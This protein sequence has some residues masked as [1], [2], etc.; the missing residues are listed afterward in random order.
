MSSIDF[1]SPEPPAPSPQRSD[2]RRFISGAWITGLGTLAS[3]VLGLLRDIAT[4]ALLGLAAYGVAD[5]LVVAIR[6]P[7]LFRRIFGEGALTASFI[8]AFA[9]EYEQSADDGWKLAT[10]VLVWLTL[11][12]TAIVLIAEII[13]GVAWLWAR[14]SPSAALLISFIAAN[15]PYAITICVASLLGATLQAVGRFTVAAWAPTLLNICWLIAAWFVAPGVSDDRVVQAWVIIGSIQLAGLL[16]AIVHLPAL[17][18]AGFHF[19]YDWQSSRAKVK[20][21]ARSIAAVTLGLTITQI[22]TLLD[23]MVAWLLATAPDGPTSATWLG[24][25]AY[26]MRS[27]AA[28]AVYYGERFYQ[29]PVG[30]LGFAIATAIFPLLSRHAAKGDHRLLGA[31]LTVALRVA[32][33]TS[34]PAGIGLVLIADPLARLIYQHGEFT[35]EDAAR[36]AR[37]IATYSIAVWAFCT[38]PVVVR[39]FY[40]HRDQVTPMRI[41]LVAVFVN[42]LLDFTLVWPLAEVGL[43]LST[44]LAAML[45][46]VLLTFVFARRYRSLNW[47]SLARSIA[48]IVAATAAMSGTVIAILRSLRPEADWSTQA[49]HLALAIAAG[50]GVFVVISWIIGSEELSLLLRTNP[51]ADPPATP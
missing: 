26:P 12:L 30:I 20:K 8:P 4:A 33:F 1:P 45:Q 5:A 22:N 40:A 48:Q 28:A 37:M 21:I 31:D 19:A 38:A 25:I 15:L 49:V 9:T 2:H 41:G 39:G 47:Q 7:N 24:G 42:V 29:L 16:Q 6:I 23:S 43:A 17:R 34:I 35:A 46:L 27:G 11:V 18:N 36:T 14:N 44:A 3:R 13:L 50:A 32:L 10:A 51:P